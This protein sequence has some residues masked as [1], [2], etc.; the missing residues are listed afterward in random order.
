[1]YQLS[2]SASISFRNDLTV[3]INI[4]GLRASIVA[5]DPTEDDPFT[6]DQTDHEDEII[7]TKEESVECA[8]QWATIQRGGNIV[9]LVLD[10]RLI[11]KGMVR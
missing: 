10:A 5:I 9:P 4:G 8:Y 11:R 7:G 3:P 1:M 6:G 2:F